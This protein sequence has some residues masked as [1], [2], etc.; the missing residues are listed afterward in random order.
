MQHHWSFAP[1]TRPHNKM[2]AT[3]ASLPP[4][5]NHALS[6]DDVVRHSD[7]LPA[8]EAEALRLRLAGFLYAQ[9]GNRLGVR[10]G[11]ARELVRQA[12]ERLYQAKQQADAPPP[13]DPHDPAD[14]QRHQDHD[15]RRLHRNG[16]QR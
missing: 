5:Y 9:I 8:R 7:M 13:E 12:C 2:L 3:H 1:F 16:R 6:R 14:D 15:S 11:R 4:P 10:T